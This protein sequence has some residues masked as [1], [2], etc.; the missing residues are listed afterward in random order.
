MTPEPA[1]V[2]GYQQAIDTLTGV[3]QRT[4]S[5]A[6]KWAADYLAAD[7]DN[8]RP[9]CLCGADLGSPWDSVP[10][11]RGAPGCRHFPAQCTRQLDVEPTGAPDEDV[12]LG[13]IDPGTG[14]CQTC[15]KDYASGAPVFSLDSRRTEPDA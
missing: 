12:C 9:E 8:L 4:G 10:H 1:A 7:P 13:A 11:R 14:R 5:P 15:G 3:F 2:D 6:A